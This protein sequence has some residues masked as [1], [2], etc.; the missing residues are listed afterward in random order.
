M[1]CGI[2]ERR[3]EHVGIVTVPLSWCLCCCFCVFLGA[4]PHYV[5][6]TLA[7]LCE[8]RLC[9]DLTEHDLAR[10]DIAS[11]LEETTR[12]RSMTVKWRWRKRHKNR[13][14]QSVIWDETRNVI[15][16]RRMSFIEFCSETT[17][18]SFFRILFS[19]LVGRERTCWHRQRPRNRIKFGEPAV[20]VS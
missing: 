9:C 15:V 1:L 10:E 14:I 3:Q 18:N 8:Q 6:R 20:P 13:V 5:I 19:I 4:P 17:L 11:R 12:I 7:A 2:L 16:P